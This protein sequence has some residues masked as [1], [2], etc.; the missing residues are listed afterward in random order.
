[1]PTDQART[2]RHAL[3]PRL[4]PSPNNTTTTMHKHCCYFQNHTTILYCHHQL[5]PSACITTTLTPTSQHQHLHIIH[6]HLTDTTGT[7]PLIYVP[8]SPPAA[9]LCNQPTNQPA[10]KTFHC[11]CWTL[12]KI[13]QLWL[14]CVWQ[15]LLWKIMA[16]SVVCAFKSTASST[17]ILG[18]SPFPI[19]KR[20]DADSSVSPFL[21]LCQT[22]IHLPEAN[23]TIIMDLGIHFR[24]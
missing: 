17:E 9:N 3:T 21:K 4:P 15:R 22:H 19:D 16:F 2:C 1:M 10:G 8:P 12:H 5:S 24:G 11:S 18:I 23:I 7:Q 20:T 6:C 13:S 14:L